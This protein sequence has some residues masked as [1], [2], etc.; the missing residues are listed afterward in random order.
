MEIRV[1]GSFDKDLVDKVAA[2]SS[3]YYGYLVEHRENYF[4]LN[5]PNRLHAEEFIN[6]F[7]GPEP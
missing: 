3:E 5:F 6:D 2:I 1:D 4:I 7:C